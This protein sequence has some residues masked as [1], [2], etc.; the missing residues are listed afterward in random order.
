MLF[1]SMNNISVHAQ[2]N[3]DN[4]YFGEGI[5]LNKNTQSIDSGQFGFSASANSINIQTG[6]YIFTDGFRVY[7]FQNQIIDAGDSLAI[8][9]TPF[10]IDTNGNYLFSSNSVMSSILLPY[11]ENNNHFVLFSN[12]RSNSSGIQGWMENRMGINYSV[13][14]MNQNGGLGKVI[15]K[16]IQL[17]HDTV[18]QGICA[19]QHANGR[20]WWIFT[21]KPQSG[22]MYRILLDPTGIHLDSIP[23]HLPDGYGCYTSQLAFSPSGNYFANMLSGPNLNIVQ[24]FSFDRCTGDF[25]FIKEWPI[26]NGVFGNP[27]GI[28]FSPNEQFL[29]YAIDHTIVHVGYLFQ[30][31]LTISIPDV[32]T[33]YTIANRRVTSF[34]LMDSS[35]YFAEDF[36]LPVTIH[37]S[38]NMYLSEIKYPNQG[39]PTCIVIPHSFYLQGRRNFSCLPNNVN[40]SLGPVTGSAC[41]TLNLGVHELE[42][43]NLGISPNPATNSISIQ[44]SKYMSSITVTDALGRVCL[45]QTGNT[46]MMEMDITSLQPGCYFIT[47][48]NKNNEVVANG[49]FVKE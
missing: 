49:K 48:K 13:I 5:I 45:Q 21:R 24:L 30:T 2:F 36:H 37:D 10:D 42:P 11:P 4:L 38:T 39:Y 33:I 1:M 41:D 28:A 34:T 15:Q 20:D 14:D 7:N 16:N 19:I 40:F 46:Q 26:D 18:C 3:S 25:T 43:V 17:V 35:I 6:N 12:M 29:Y 27:L 32:T 8:F 44:C 9:I 23:L 22:K 31:D 47:A